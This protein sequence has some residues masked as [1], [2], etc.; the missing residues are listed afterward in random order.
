MVAKQPFDK[1]FK[2]FQLYDSKKNVERHLV[3]FLFIKVCEYE[4]RVFFKA[5]NHTFV[6]FFLLFLKI[7]INIPYLD[8]KN[9][10][11][12]I[13]DINK[14]LLFPYVDLLSVN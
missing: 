9:I 1:N 12:F 5:K 6:S 7:K 8:K 11:E 3:S 13:C 4:R 10:T 14:Y 2:W